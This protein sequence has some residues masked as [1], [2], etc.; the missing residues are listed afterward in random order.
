M[1]IFFLPWLYIWEVLAE[2]FVESCEYLSCQLSKVQLMIASVPVFWW[3][4]PRPEYEYKEPCLKKCMC[5]HTSYTK[6]I[7]TICL[8][9]SFAT[10]GSDMKGNTVQIMKGITF[11]GT[12]EKSQCFR[13]LVCPVVFFSGIIKTTPLAKILSSIVSLMAASPLPL[14]KIFCS[15][16]KFLFRT[17]AFPSVSEEL[18]WVALGTDTPDG[19]WHKALFA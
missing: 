19:L 17:S 15:Q 2:H 3:L 9:L 12:L 10:I 1:M 7:S 13:K 18:R 5:A 8:A 14:Q 6:Q 11:T 16:E 4:E